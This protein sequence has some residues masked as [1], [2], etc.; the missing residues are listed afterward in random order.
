MKSEPSPFTVDWRGQGANSTMASGQRGS[1]GTRLVIEEMP[2][3]ILTDN[4][5]MIGS[6]FGAITDCRMAEEALRES[7]VCLKA[8]IDNLPIGVWFVNGSAKMLHGN[9]AGHE[10]VSGAI[11]TSV[12]RSS[13]STRPGRRWADGTEVVT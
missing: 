3:A 1:H 8:I 10:I 5:Y 9:A 7:T 12:R 6:I 2:S 13:S 11:N 4:W